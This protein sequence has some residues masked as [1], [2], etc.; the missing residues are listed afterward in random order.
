MPSIPVAYL[1]EHGQ[2]M[3]IVIM[4]KN[5]VQ[6]GPSQ[7]EATIGQLQALA[8][9]NG[10]NGTVAMVWDDGGKMNYLVP[11]PWHDFFQSITLDDVRQRINAEI[12]W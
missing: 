12:R 1:H 6:A 4:D 3:V 2:D 9:L 7:Q 5:F 8:K 11:Q 10:L